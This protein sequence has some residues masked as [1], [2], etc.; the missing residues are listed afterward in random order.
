MAVVNQQ[1]AT[2]FNRVE[3]SKGF[4][5]QSRTWMSVGCY[6]DWDQNC[7]SITKKSWEMQR[8]RRRKNEVAMP[9]GLCRFLLSQFSSAAPT[10]KLPTLLPACVTGCHFSTLPHFLVDSSYMLQL[11][12]IWWTKPIKWLNSTLLL[13]NISCCI[14]FPIRYKNLQI[15][16]K[17]TRNKTALYV[18]F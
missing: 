5:F 7:F 6:Q 17:R 4:N 3:R 16:Q 13:P 15:N 10:H 8:M 18:L 14:L 9:G 2:I 11:Q 12:S 1:R